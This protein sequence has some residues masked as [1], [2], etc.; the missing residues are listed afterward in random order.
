MFNTDVKRGAI[1]VALFLLLVC[2]SNLCLAFGISTPYIVNDTLKIQAGNSYKYTLTI[3]NSEPE[4]Y[5]VDI[6]YSST[7]NVVSLEKTAYYTSSN[8]YN[9]TFNFNIL[10]PNEAKLGEKYLLEYTAKPRTSS[11]SNISQ[12]LEI[13]GH[14]NILVVDK[15]NNTG[16]I[17][18]TNAKQQGSK[19]SLRTYFLAIIIVI[20]IALIIMR[21]WKLSQGLSSKISNESVTNFTISQAINLKEVQELLEKIS[22]EEFRLPEIKKLFKEKISE[23]TKHN[24]AKDIKDM[25]RKEVILAIEKIK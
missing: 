3:Q 4:D 22:D 18:E 5:Y 1:A 21:V 7:K 11:T 8:T 15:N 6:N 24:I 10:V 9:N 12:S 19:H 2:L 25:S 17:Q 23:L 13:K 20:L 16:V 14:L